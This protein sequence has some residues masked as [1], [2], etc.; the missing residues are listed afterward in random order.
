VIFSTLTPSNTYKFEQAKAAEPAPETTNFTSLI[1]FCA[2]SNG[3]MIM[4]SGKGTNTL[5]YSYDGI[6]WTG[7]S[8][9]VFNSESF[10][11]KWNGKF[12]I[13]TG[14]GTGNYTIAI[15]SD[16]L[17]WSPIKNSLFTSCY[18]IFCFSN[19]YTCQINNQINLNNS[20]SLDIVTDK[21]YNIGPTNLTIEIVLYKN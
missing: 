5:A 12:W 3:N 1:S 14:T 9:N 18:N 11:V 8:N 10:S 20:D 6:N 17:K 19:L 21:Y 13:G 16:G 2:N 4:A 7:L 15:S